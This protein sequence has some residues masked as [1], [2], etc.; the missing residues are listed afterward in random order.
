MGSAPGEGAEAWLGAREGWE[1]RKTD[2]A[3][4]LHAMGYGHTREI[5]TVRVGEKIANL[6]QLVA[7][8]DEGMLRLT[9]VIGEVELRQPAEGPPRS[10]CAAHLDVAALRCGTPG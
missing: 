2:F 7:M 10:A 4:S 8:D 9:P 3:P 6:S 1:R 5:V